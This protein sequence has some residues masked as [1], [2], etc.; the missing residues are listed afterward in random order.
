VPSA[1][2]LE[3]MKPSLS[4]LAAEL[5]VSQGT[6]ARMLRKLAAE[7]PQLVRIRPRWGVFRPRPPY[8][9]YAATIFNGLCDH[10]RAMPRLVAN[11]VR[12]CVCI[13]LRKELAT[14]GRT[15]SRGPGKPGSELVAMSLFIA[16]RADAM[17]SS[18]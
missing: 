11:L 2:H 18:V 5:E 17:I 13:T 9:A 15:T 6:V 3:M 4:Q 1:A 14:F 10:T 7:D 8:G 16:T 12:A